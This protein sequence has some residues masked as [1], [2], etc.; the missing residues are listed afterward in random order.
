V[1]LR[2]AARI[3]RAT[4]AS[5]RSVHGLDDDLPAAVLSAQSDVLE[6]ALRSSVGTME[7]VAALSPQVD[8]EVGHIARLLPQIAADRGASL[9]VL[10]SHRGRGL[11]DLFGTPTLTRVMGASQIPILVAV[12]KPV[13]PWTQ[14]L[15]GWD[16]S[17]AAQAAARLALSLA[18][19]VTLSL[20]HAW[21]DP[22]VVSPYAFEM[23]GMATGQTIQQLE[24]SLAD[25]SGEIGNAP[26]AEG[27][28]HA[29]VIGHPAEVLLRQARSERPDV[30]VIGRHAR[31]GILRFVMGDT[32]A[33]AALHAPC[34]VLIAPPD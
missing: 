19:D 27:I 17:P 10:G 13:A 3:A 25:A 30:L 31:A 12:T 7:D 6:Y 15:V 34:D 32:A 4:G 16:F 18:P 20:L 1:A 11:A 5:L 9:L 29:A 24:A 28:A 23:G 22:G 8:V 33:R 21:V 2:R 26:G 14:A